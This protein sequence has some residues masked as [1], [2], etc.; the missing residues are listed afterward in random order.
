M[1]TANTHERI[2]R[3]LENLHHLAKSSL[4][5]GRRTAFY[6]YSIKKDN[7]MAIFQRLKLSHW[8]RAHSSNLMGETC[9]SAA[10]KSVV[11][12]FSFTTKSHIFIFTILID[13]YNDFKNSF[14]CQL[15]SIPSS[16]G[17][18]ERLFPDLEKSSNWLPLISVL[19]L[20]CLS[21]F[22]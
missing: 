17:I 22:P 6:V 3:R 21:N 19:S 14:Y 12:L 11:V 16:E 7:E 2:R 10:P 1:L 13:G 5:S 20:L 9:K 18:S 4:V 15:Y 8:L